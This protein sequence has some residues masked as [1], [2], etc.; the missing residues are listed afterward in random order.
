MVVL[1]TGELMR[2]RRVRQGFQ[3]MV[4]GLWYERGLLLGPAR[5]PGAG[6][7][8]DWDAWEYCEGGDRSVPEYFDGGEGLV[9]VFGDS[10]KGFLD[11]AIDRLAEKGR[12][13]EGT[14]ER[15]CSGGYGHGSA[16][17]IISKS[18]ISGIPGQLDR[19]PN[20]PWGSSS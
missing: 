15:Y 20:P 18:R 17:G 1:G 2:L 8:G 5:C 11:G 16:F 13:P 6:E 14:G 10:G 12:E 19:G 7:I 9:P 4:G 3:T